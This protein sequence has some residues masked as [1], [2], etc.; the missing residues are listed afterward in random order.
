LQD[1]LFVFHPE[2]KAVLEN[3]LKT[4]N[5]LWNEALSYHSDWLLQHVKHIVPGPEVLL[6]HV[7]AVLNVCGPL[8]NPTSGWPLFNSHAWEVAA[9]VLENIQR[10]YYSDPPNSSFYHPSGKDKHGLMRYQCVRGTN[11]IK[12]G[13]HQNVIQWFRAFNASPDFADIWT[14][15][16]ISHLIDVIT[17]AFTCDVTNLAGS[18]V[19]GNN[20]QHSKD[21][22][23]VLPLL[24]LQKE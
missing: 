9:N 1:A 7:A 4:K 20:Y 2:D 24:K 14:Q 3:F 16:H 18:W 15:N 11:A 8:L 19:N 5:S 6:P 10:G 21:I 23:R 13:I 17:L 22:F 12:G